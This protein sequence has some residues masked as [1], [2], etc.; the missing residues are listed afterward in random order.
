MNA[1]LNAKVRVMK[2][3]IDHQEYIA[4]G[5]YT[6]LCAAN[7]GRKLRTKEEYERRLAECRECCPTGFCSE[8][9]CNYRAKLVL[10]AFVC[11]R[12]KFAND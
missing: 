4:A 8:C 2:K 1:M 5:G 12:G 6:A 10:R 3:R 11:G 7:P 9:G